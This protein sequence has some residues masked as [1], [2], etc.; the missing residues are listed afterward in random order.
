MSNTNTA[1]VI[2][3][4]L[5]QFSEEEI[6]TMKNMI[7]AERISLSQWVRTLILR[8]IRRGREEGKS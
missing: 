1:P 6:Q 2:H 7:H 4:Y 8:E 3:V 5:S